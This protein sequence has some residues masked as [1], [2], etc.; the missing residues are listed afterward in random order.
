MRNIH[1]LPRMPVIAVILL[2]LL[3][4]LPGGAFAVFCTGLPTNCKTWDTTDPLVAGTCCIQASGNKFRRCQ[5]SSEVKSVTPFS[6][7]Q[8]A[9]LVDIVEGACGD[10]VTNACGG[11]TAIAGCTSLDCPGS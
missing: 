2:C 6:G 9:S 5:S 8:C 1:L 3:N 7:H 4:S 11:T 10:T